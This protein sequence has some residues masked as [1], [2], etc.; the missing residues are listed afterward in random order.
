MAEIE[1]EC[2]L[3]SITNEDWEIEI[4]KSVMASNNTK[5]PSSG[6][7]ESLSSPGRKYYIYIIYISE[8]SHPSKLHLFK[9][10]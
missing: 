1:Q 9:V 5:D 10:D 7:E 3:E 4:I 6:S 8:L 2:K